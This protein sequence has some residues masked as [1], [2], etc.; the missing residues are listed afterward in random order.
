VAAHW[1]TSKPGLPLFR[2]LVKDSVTEAMKGRSEIQ[3]APDDTARAIQEQ[4]HKSSE[5]RV[6]PIRLIGDAVIAAFFSAVKPRER[7]K[8]RADV[9]SWLSG[10]PVA[11]D[12][13]AAMSATLKQDTHPLTPFHWELEFPEVFTREN[14][15]FDA[16]VG[17]P[18]FAGKNTTI[19]SNRDGYLDWLKALHEGVH[20]NADLVAHFFRRAFALLRRDACFGLIA[21]NTI[22]QGDTRATGLAAILSAKG[23]IWRAIKRLPWPGEA[24]VTVS[25]VHLVKGRVHSPVLDGRPVTRIS[26]YLVEGEMDGA[27]ARLASNERKAFIGSYLLGMGFTFDD[28]AA[29]KGEAEPISE[30]EWLITKNSHNAERI[31]PYIGGEE[32]TNSPTHTAHRYAIDFE[33]FPR[34][35][36]DALGSWK[37]A[38]QDQRRE[39]LAHYVVPTDYPFPV[40]SDWPDLLQILNRRVRPIRL[41]QSSTVN[42]DR[43]WMHARPA[44]RLKAA[45]S[46]FE[47][48]LVINCGATPQFGACPQRRAPRRR[49][50]PRHRAGDEGEG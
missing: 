3:A 30:M 22:G 40:A 44:T 47:D 29:A 17:N 49:S 42:P 10:S 14:G 43:W 21:T 12:K 24:A 26:A 1:D 16:I 18:P 8:K 2:Q 23:A 45:T 4:R 6:A 9:E 28:I 38:S 15:G 25:V 41:T 39:W 32:V 5:A 34:E 36:S 27:P 33:A 20:G 37:L 50:P 19:R 13:L 11:W 35:R 48:V 46:N 31:R 7:E